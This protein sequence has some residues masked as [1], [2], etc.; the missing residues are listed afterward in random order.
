M[1]RGNVLAKIARIELTHVRLLL[2]YLSRE[3]RASFTLE[4]V[5]RTLG[6]ANWLNF[7]P[8]Y[9]AL[10]LAKAERPDTD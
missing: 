2:F 9:R 7:V 4:C 1:R 10:A 3:K 8:V 6:T 5:L